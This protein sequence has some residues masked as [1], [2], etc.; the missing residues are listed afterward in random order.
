MSSKKIV[1]GSLLAGM[2]FVTGIAFTPWA[3]AG[4]GPN[5]EYKCK[6]LKGTI[7]SNLD[8]F[9]ATG[10]VTGSFAGTINFATVES[11]FTHP[12]GTTNIRSVFTGTI[13]P[14]KGAPFNFMMDLVAVNWTASGLVG[15]GVLNVDLVPGGSSFSAIHVTLGPMDD[16]ASPGGTPPMRTFTYE[17]QRCT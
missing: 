13:T 8:G 9:P 2:L 11:D 5:S 10:T 7:E 6:N 12:G 16:R 15:G 14:K 3:G 17:G 1:I 4:G